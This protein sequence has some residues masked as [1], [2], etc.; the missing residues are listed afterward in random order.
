MLV[1]LCCLN[2]FSSDWSS[3]RFSRRSTDHTCQPLAFET[4]HL[5][6]GTKYVAPAEVPG[7]STSTFFASLGP[8]LMMPTWLY[9][10]GVPGAA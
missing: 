1:T 10:A 9:R 5:A 7:S 4:I 2:R 6:S 3:R 8:T